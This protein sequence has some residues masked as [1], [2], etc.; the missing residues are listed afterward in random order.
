MS[1]INEN[2]A[3]SQALLQTAKFMAIAARTAPKA[4][5]IGNIDIK[6]ITGTEIEQLASK[7]KEMS[8]TDGRAFF[9]RDAA[10]IE[11]SEVVVFIGTRIKPIGLKEC[12]LCGLDN[13]DNKNLFPDVPCAF[14]T[15]DLGIAI[16]SAVSVAARFQADNRIMFSAGKA[17]VALNLFA[18]E[19]QIV[20]GIP[21]SASS[22]SP[23]FDRKI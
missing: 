21:L 8:R 22:K 19:I 17:A 14:N 15:G 3:L 18:P 4:R 6:I 1:I 5:G 23:F 11:I 20:Y 9:A 10:N 7:M 16:G 2:E 13:C 12:G